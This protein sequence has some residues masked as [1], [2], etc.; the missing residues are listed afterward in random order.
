MGATVQIHKAVIS[1]AEEILSLQKLA[2]SK[3]SRNLRR[4]Q[5]RAPRSNDSGNGTDIEE[6]IVSQGRRGRKDHRL[7][8]GE[9]QRL[10]LFH[11]RLIVHPDFQNRGIRRLFDE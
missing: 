3:R 7:S 5:H 6:Q 9:A 10:R 11:R 2:I 1:D 4:L 8:E